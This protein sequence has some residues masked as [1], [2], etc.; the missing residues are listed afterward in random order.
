MTRSLRIG[1]V[2]AGFAGR[3][4]HL[5]AWALVPGASVVAVC[6]IDP[7]ARAR[8]AAQAPGARL[9]ADHRDLLSFGVDAVSVCTPNVSHFPVAR[10]ALEAGVHAL[11]EKP[12]CV[13]PA[14]VRALGEA[15]DARGLVLMARHQLRFD[16][17]AGAVHA[18]ASSLGRIVRVN[19]RALRRDR[20]PTTRGLTDAALAGGGAALDLGVHALDMALWL[21]GF[22]S[23]AGAR[24]VATTRNAYGRGEVAGYRNHWGDWDRAGFTVEDGA[25]AQVTFADGAILS[26]ECA[27]AGAWSEAEEGTHCEL[28]GE[29]GTLSWRAAASSSRRLSSRPPPEFTAFAEACRGLIPPPLPWR[30]TVAS[31]EILDAVYRAAREQRPVEIRGRSLA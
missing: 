8:A 18:R 27:W 14:E 23:R 4:A 15:A 6:D 28:I 31:L 12:V 7:A 20:I 25:S 22:P 21:T 17:E 19:A 26:L 1:V 24:V 3:S 16:P 30:E 11:V 29:A 5:P 9:F 10:A 2:G 13:T